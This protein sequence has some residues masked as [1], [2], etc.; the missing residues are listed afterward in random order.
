MKCQQHTQSAPIL[1]LLINPIQRENY[2]FNKTSTEDS[3]L[4]SILLKLVMINRARYIS[5]YGNKCTFPYEFYL[6]LLHLTNMSFVPSNKSSEIHIQQ[7]CNAMQLTTL[8]AVHGCF[9]G[10]LLH[11][12]IQKDSRKMLTY[13]VQFGSAPLERRY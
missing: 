8:S 13:T 12:I 7:I 11:P 6:Y 3:S 4:L 5:L 9:L 1:A 2:K 10:Y